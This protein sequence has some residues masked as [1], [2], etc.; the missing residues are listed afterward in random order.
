MRRYEVGPH[1]NPKVPPARRPDGGDTRRLGRRHWALLAL[2][3]EHGVLHTGQITALLFGSRPAAVRHLT[4]LMRAGLVRRF[5]H[6]ND[7]THLAYY[8]L[9][10]DG[11]ERLT[12][13]L[14]EA[15]RPVP[16]AMGKPGPDLFVVNEFFVGLVGEARRQGRGVLFRW[17]RALEAAVWL[18][19]HAVPAAPSAYG[20]W[21]EDGAAV[22]FLL[23]VD[24]D[25]PGR[26]SSTPAPPAAAWLADY[27]QAPRGVPATAVL[28]LCPTRQR[29]DELHRDL[30]ADPLPVTVATTTFEQ[31]A[32]A[33]NGAEAIWR[34][35]GAEPAVLL[36]L[37]EIGR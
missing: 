14:R 13:R 7:P 2:L 26:L 35:V 31:L 5:V 6:R 19:E 27:R 25:K 20:V 9:S 32:T 11:A 3:A 28:V 4:R 21:I 34:V 22:R 10:A 15:N 37:A 12:V 1:G 33:G 30:T 23:H 16:V 29:E 18:R 8:E 17:R 24:H 36:R